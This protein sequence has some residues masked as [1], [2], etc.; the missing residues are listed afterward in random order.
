MTLVYYGRGLGPRDKF[1][2]VL[3]S[4]FFKSEL[5]L[6]FH[7]SLILFHSLLYASIKNKT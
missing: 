5:K 4:S 3:T 6:T 2:W 1:I 7:V